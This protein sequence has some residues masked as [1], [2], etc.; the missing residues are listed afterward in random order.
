MP[1]QSI[2]VARMSRS[3]HAERRASAATASKMQT[4]LEIAFVMIFSFVICYILVNSSPNYI[5]A[6]LEGGTIKL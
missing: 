5:I 2:F 4:F 6:V 3:S 1:G